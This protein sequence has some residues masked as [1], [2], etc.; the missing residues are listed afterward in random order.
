MVDNDR[1]RKRA[2]YN[3]AFKREA[4]DLFQNSDKTMAEIER[5]LGLSQ[6]LLKQWVHRAKLGGEDI[7]N[8]DGEFSPESEEIRRLKRE[9]NSLRLDNE[10]LKKTIAIFSHPPKPG[11]DT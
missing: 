7:F 4:I 3:A 8:G 6:G 10:I 5:E 9:N 2:R 11:S 1:N